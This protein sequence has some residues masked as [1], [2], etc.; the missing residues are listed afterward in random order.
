MEIHIHHLTKII[1][2]V[3][4]LDDVS[5]S[6]YGGKVYGL[7]GKNGSGKTM[8]MRCLCGLILPSSGTISIDGAIIG[9]DISFPPSVGALIENPSFLEGYTGLQNLSMLASIRGVTDEMQIRD[10]IASVGLDA[11]DKRK[12]R[13]YSL[14]MKQRLG[15][16]CA[17]M[18]SPKL[19]I[20]DEP[21]NALD[22]TGIELVKKAIIARRDQG[23]LIVVSCH[24]TAELEFLSDE[25]VYIE[26]GRVQTDKKPEGLL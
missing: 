2:G 16:A 18:E 21:L 12:Y 15:I 11:G 17:L 13:K 4:V 19:I 24:D 26:Q 6:L 22:E 20:L 5:L 1:R 9:K 10:T 23:A 8:L 7:Q 14:G 25:M 3:T